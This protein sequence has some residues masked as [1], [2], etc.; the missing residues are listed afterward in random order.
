MTQYQP[1]LPLNSCSS[2]SA[3]VPGANPFLDP[4][5]PTFATMKDRIRADG[6]LSPQLRADLQSA[7][8]TFARLMGQKPEAMPALASV[9]RPRLK[10]LTPTVTGLSDKRLANIK[11]SVLRAIVRYGGRPRRHAFG[12]ITP[13]WRTV[14]DRLTVYQRA[15]LSRFIAWCSAV[16]IEP[17]Q[18]SDTVVARFQNELIEESFV[19]RPTARVAATCREWQHVR[20]TMPDLKLPAVSI[21]QN[22]QTYVLKDIAFPP[23]FIADR[24]RFCARL[25]GSDPFSEDGPPRPLKPVSVKRRHFQ[26]MQLASGLVHSG[27]LATEIRSL[28]DL[29]AP[30]ALRDSLKYFLARAGGATTTQ[31]SQLGFVA[32]MIARHWVSCEPQTLGQIERIA[33]KVAM[34]QRG[35]TPKNRERLRQFDDA[36]HVRRMLFFADDLMDELRRADDRRAPTAL[37]AQIAAAVAILIAAPIRLANLVSL[38]LDIHIQRSRTGNDA[39]W[40]LVL[41]EH[42]TKN[43]E[44]REHPLGQKPQP[45]CVNI[46]TATGRALRRLGTITSFRPAQGIR[47]RTPWARLWPS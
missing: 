18:V 41:A 43:Q 11:S 28:S 42:E 32:K 38:R 26:I 33:A 36:E 19:A 8:N 40:H 34:R 47:R 7:L 13:G 45:C 24:D 3:S 31:I 21:P 22:R 46:G 16:G 37:K 6:S 5:I 27:T 4:Q 30:D 39:G 9:Y 25:G 35:L 1:T 14:T 17:P 2:P 10:R 20:A 29:V 12:E 23:S 15:S 44:P